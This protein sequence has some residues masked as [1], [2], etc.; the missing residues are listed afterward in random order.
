MNTRS[1]GFQLLMWY[2]GLLT[3][4][5]VLFGVFMY[6]DLKQYLERD[7]KD[8]Q[9]HRARVIAQ[10]L[11][12][13]AAA[14]GETYV[15]DEINTRYAPELNDRFIRITRANGSVMY[16]SGVPKDGTF[17]ATHLPVLTL[18]VRREFA[19]K[20]TVSGG[21]ELLI[22]T[23][24]VSQSGKHDYTV[25][26]G[27]SLGAIHTVLDQ[28]LLSLV[29]GLPV[30]VAVAI[31]G[32]YLLVRRALA[33]VD[34]MA[35]SAEQITL[36]NLDDRLPISPTGD[37]LERLS[38]SLNHMITR[39]DESFQQTRRFIAD[40]SHELRTP[41]TIMRGELETIVQ[42]PRLDAGLRE[43]AGSVLEEVERLAKIVE[44]L[45]A[46]SRLDAGEAQTEWVKFDLA[47]LAATTTEQMCLLAEDKGIAVTC[48]A[49]RAV[50]VEGDRARLKQ[51]VVNLLDNAIKYTPRGGS[52]S[53]TVGGTNGTA[54]LE[55]SDNGIGIPVD[56]LPHVFERFF[57][58][59]KARSREMGGAGIGLSIVKAICAAHRGQVE[60]QSTEGHGSRFRVNLPLSHAAGGE[61]SYKN[62]N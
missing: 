2:A 53:L 58:V 36:H 46:L 35:R 60:V 37:E 16:G 9:F 4:V 27:A 48:S 21:K 11:L 51:V 47:D 6:T 44:S 30:V 42:Q 26:V 29:A 52:V 32:G 14:T 54:F 17:D 19:R 57:R 15:T 22:A 1:L 5:F 24:P 23:V 33:P 12:S 25:E 55:V 40:A 49:P 10:T 61:G 41:L 50:V 34:K 43:S 8:S 18:P 7:L 62:G 31:G 13:R 59:D 39:L 45:F 3:G 28:L 38:L 20:E 56:A